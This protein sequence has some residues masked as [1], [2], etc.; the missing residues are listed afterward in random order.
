M[1][2][3]KTIHRACN[4]CEAQCG[5]SYDVEGDAITCVR[6]DDEDRL[7][8]GYVGPKGLANIELYSD[9]DRLRTPV[10]RTPAGDFE[11]IGWDVALSEAVSGLEEVRRRAGRK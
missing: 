9:P 6:A 8:P 7:S 3:V 11:P 4:L 2:D 1:F 10:R 5:L